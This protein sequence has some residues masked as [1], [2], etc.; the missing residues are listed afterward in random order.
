MWES[1]VKLGLSERVPNNRTRI[2]HGAWVSLLKPI[3]YGWMSCS[4]LMQRR[5]ALSCLNLFSILGLTRSNS[6]DS[7]FKIDPW[8]LREGECYRQSSTLC[9]HC[10]HSQNCS[11]Y[12]DSFMYS[13]RNYAYRMFNQ[14]KLGN[15]LYTPYSKPNLMIFLHYHKGCWVGPRKLIGK[16]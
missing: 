6:K 10:F 15:F 9:Q 4:A 3:P 7:L 2:Y 16:K 12:H 5:G 11:W 1:V 14:T 13:S 8:I